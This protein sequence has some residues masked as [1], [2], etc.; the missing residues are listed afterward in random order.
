MGPGPLSVLD[1]A[2]GLERIMGDH[3]LYARMLARFRKDYRDGA[4]A[5][6]QALAAGQPERARRI[7][8][9]LKG[10]AGMLGAHALHAL[11]GQLERTMDAP[12]EALAALAAALAA[13]LERI[14]EQL[15][16][17]P[18]AAPPR[19][20][21][22]GPADHAALARL[23]RLLQ[24]GDGA[25]IDVLDDA[26]ASLL[27]VLGGARLAALTKAA[28][29]FDFDGALDALGGAGGAPAGGA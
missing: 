29:D 28:E 22:A 14:D 10:A 9:T 27:A 23:R 24:A 2:D 25:A 19:M 4:G 21:P 20:G 3:G 13:L 11:A 15:G 18:P 16:E 6:G 1:T 7:A 5:L 12:D 17:A 26:R 8:H